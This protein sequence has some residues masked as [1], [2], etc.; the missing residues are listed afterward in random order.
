MK[1][2]DIKQV[3]R[4]LEKKEAWERSMGTVLMIHLGKK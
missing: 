4:V 3:I 2:S 1:W